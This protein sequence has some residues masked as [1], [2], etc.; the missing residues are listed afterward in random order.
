MTQDISPP[1]KRTLHAILFIV[2]GYFGYSLA[3]L[4]S[5]ILQE[6]YSIHQVLGASGLSGLAITGIWLFASHG[7]RA[8]LPPRMKLHLLRAVFVTGTA[9]FMVR[10]LHTLPLADFYGIV[11]VMPF[12]AMALSVLILGE[13]V[14]WRRW[15]AASVGFSGVLVIAGP[16]FQQIGEGFI[17]A[18]LGAL[19]AA[20][21]I[22]CLR[23]IGKDQP[24]A[25]YGFYP[26]LLI[27][28]WQIGMLIQTKS[29]VPFQVADLPY[30][31]LHGPVIVMGIVMVSVGFARA[32]ETAVVA[33]FH[34]TQII[35]GVLF[36]WIFFH[37]L[38]THTTWIGIALVTGAGLY[39]LWREYI[40]H[41]Q[42]VPIRSP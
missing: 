42:S 38:P 14:G 17:C 21:N 9:Y 7:Y 39:S 34:Y 37:T 1:H 41:K 19:C 26:F 29:F 4:C 23:K 2:V 30:F 3:D 8:F 12:I 11:F 32:P 6:H 27:A 35:W 15:L 40:A 33:P 28:V 16:Q 10:S 13:K 22:I 5:K 20:A 31:L 36:G 24:L 18:L 25:L